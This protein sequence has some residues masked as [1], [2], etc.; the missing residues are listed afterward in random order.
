MYDDGAGIDGFQNV[1]V[2]QDVGDLFEGGRVRFEL[3]VGL[4]GAVSVLIK[5]VEYSHD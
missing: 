3:T 4:H 5:N 2:R 1:C